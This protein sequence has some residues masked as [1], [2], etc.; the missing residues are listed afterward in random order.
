MP[1]PIRP[2]SS[3]IPSTDGPTSAG[4]TSAGSI[5]SSRCLGAPRPRRQQG[6][7]RRRARQR[8]RLCQRSGFPFTAIDQLAFNRFLADGPT[9]AAS[10]S[11]SRTT[12]T[13]SAD[14][15]DYFDCALN[16]QC[17]EWDECDMLQPFIDAGKAVLGVEYT[18]DPLEF[19][20]YF[21]NLQYSWMKKDLDLDA[22]RI[23][24]HDR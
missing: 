14:L 4:W 11:P 10:R 6:L 24:C 1:A 12:S 18:G 13:R 19:C 5:F 22:W 17:H 23:D 15:V 8:R 7:R 20:S 16:E 3:A 21:N 2:R 9:P